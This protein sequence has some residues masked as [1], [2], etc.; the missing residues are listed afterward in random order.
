M[1][2]KSNRD[3]WWTAVEG[4]V[5]LHV[6]IDDRVPLGARGHRWRNQELDDFFRLSLQLPNM[7]FSLTSRLCNY[8][9]QI[10]ATRDFPNKIRW[11]C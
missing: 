11:A 6:A 7:L 8:L 1:I 3:E 2:S 10:K 4:G 9:A 5:R